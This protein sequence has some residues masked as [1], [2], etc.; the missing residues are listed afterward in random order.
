MEERKAGQG[1][2]CPRRREE[3]Y[4]FSTIPHLMNYLFEFGS[5][6]LFK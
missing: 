3:K 1:E 2:K 6:D 5:V 4:T